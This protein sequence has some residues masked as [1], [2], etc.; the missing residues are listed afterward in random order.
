[1][2]Y[3]QNPESGIAFVII[4]LILAIFATLFPER[5]DKK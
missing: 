3:I 4:I 1:M 2:P 5:D